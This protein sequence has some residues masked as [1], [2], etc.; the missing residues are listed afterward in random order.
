MNKALKPL[1]TRGL[2]AALVATGLMIALEL[3]TYDIL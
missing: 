2:F 3:D 1:L